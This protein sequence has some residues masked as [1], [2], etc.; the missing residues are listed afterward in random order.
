MH[1]EALRANLERTA[2]EVV[3]PQD[4]RALLDIATP[5]LGVHQNTERLLE[6]INHTFVGWIDIVPELHSRAMLDFYFY[7]G[8]DRGSEALTIYC[9]LYAKAVCE[10]NPEEL[11]SDAVRRWIAYLE[12]IADESGGRLGRNVTAID[13]S[14]ARLEEIVEAAPPL[15]APASARLQRLA[16]VLSRDSEEIPATAAHTLEVLSGV[17][18]KVY[19]MWLGRDDPADWWTELR[20]DT[21]TDQALPQAVA[22]VSHS[23]LQSYLVE[24]GTI[25]DTAATAE[26]GPYLLALPDHLAIIRSYLDVADVLQQ[27]VS[28]SEADAHD[29]ARWLCRIL[30]EEALAPIHEN[31]LWLLAKAGRS[32][33]GD[34]EHGDFDRFVRDVFA[35]L[36]TSSNGSASSA[37]DFIRSLGVST[38]RAAHPD[39]VDL[40]IEE[41]LTL[42]FHRP[43]FDGFTNDWGIRV[44][45]SHLKNIRAYLG[46]IEADPWKARE[47]L[48]ALVIYLDVGGV[49]IADTDLFQKDVSALLRTD[50]TPVYD[51]VLHLLR[52]FPVFFSDIGAEG[53]LRAVST[54]IDEIG[55]RRDPLCHFLRKQSHVES[56]PMLTSVVEEVARFWATGDPAPLERYLPDE[57]HRHLRIEDEQYR[58]LHSVFS[59]LVELRGSVDDLFD[60][61]LAEVVAALDDMSEADA[62]DRDKAALLFELR[63]ELGRKYALDHADLIE[64][65]LDSHRVDIE[66]IDA[67]ERSLNRGTYERA[68]DELLAVMEDLKAVIVDPAPTQAFEDIY[69]KR[70]I[71]TGIPSMY[72]RYREEKFE[73]AGLSFRIASLV[74]TLFDR[75]V[76]SEGFDAVSPR[77][78]LLRVSRWLR[79]LQR[80]LVVEGY[81]SWNLESSLSM[82]EEALAVRE[83]RREEF[84]EIFR[85]ITHA[86]EDLVQTKLLDTYADVFE[87]LG[88]RIL[89]AGTIEGDGEPRDEIIIKKCETFLRSLIGESMSLQRIDVLAGNVLGSLSDNRHVWPTEDDEATGGSPPVDVVRL[90]DGDRSNGLLALGN[91][92]FMLTKLADHGFPVPHGFIVTAALSRMGTSGLRDAELQSLRHRIREE[93]SV[94]ENE[95]GARFGD[96]E[97]PLLLSVRSGAPISMPGMLDSFLN[98]GI[99]A[100]IVE[101]LAA[102]SGSP[103]AAWDSYRRFLQF[104]GMSHGLERDLFD[105]LMSRAKERFEVPKKALLS[106]RR[107]RDIAIDYRELLAAEGVTVS[108]DPFD[109]LDR[110]IELVVVS[111]NSST[112]RTYRDEM[113]IADGWG[114]AV[115]VQQMV[116]GNLGV[117]TGTGVARASCSERGET[118]ELAG[119]FVIKGQGDDVVS[120]LV[121]TFPVSGAQRAGASTDVDRS[122]EM[123]FPEIYAELARLGRELI[124]DHKLPD[125]EIEF[126]FEGADPADLYILQSRESFSGG[127]EPALTFVPGEQLDESRIASG[128]GVGGGAGV[129][130]LAQSGDDIKRLREGFPDDRI[131]LVRP[132]TVPD[133]IHLLVSADA[134]LTAIGGATSHAAVVAKR[135]GKTC[136]VG[137]RGLR[138]FESE[139]R[140]EIGGLRLTAGDV[141]SISGA[142]G[143]VYLGRHDIEPGVGHQWDAT[144]IGAE[145]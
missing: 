134:L 100:Q 59:R 105:D 119:D 93:V 140:M 87:T 50:T 88:Q 76:A 121:E 69:R 77:D 20:P 79:L 57:I 35:T 55:A 70:H 19:A 139:G 126:T 60:W 135:L 54:R 96:A 41:I 129:F 32:L 6:E 24:L 92:G 106:A 17:L 51:Q 103:W 33:V 116:Y 104:W 123:D 14:L 43:E 124:V 72:G 127:A 138:V 112:A 125:Q 47:L 12:K 120:G 48:A 36:R 89:P 11:R 9:D 21:H 26:R 67:I 131:L 98:V 64:R 107:M 136:I 143:C 23:A 99:N 144:R 128:I 3:I 74:G 80:A 142:D 137:C 145:T 29:R 63:Y 114:T 71:G 8:H 65:L 16:S 83:I 133:D 45:P 10:A 141:V 7:N 58:G 117:L 37:L 122:L 108:D 111:W 118:V 78:S 5:M 109:Q 68:L 28:G 61:P 132:D 130:R 94:L 95:V 97:R 44:N 82:L 30:G 90:F 75:L 40:V 31:A 110:C 39:H 38:L 27:S 62:A 49:F 34:G 81:D 25:H 85:A 53:Q 4:Q 91:K 13:R 102:T 46:I 84:A 86:V 101:G 1:T 113:R 15:A 42:D 73:A 66:R 22:A 2:V 52:R 56:T 115:I 18:T